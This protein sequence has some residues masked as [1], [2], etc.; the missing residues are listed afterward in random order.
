MPKIKLIIKGKNIV[1]IEE[2]REV[3][4]FSDE[5][6]NKFSKLRGNIEVSLEGKKYEKSGGTSSIS[7]AYSFFLKWE[8]KT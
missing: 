6:N 3:L 7:G 2:F 5:K 1:T 8:A 4:L